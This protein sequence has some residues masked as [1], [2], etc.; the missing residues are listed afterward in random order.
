MTDEGIRL[1]AAWQFNEAVSM[2]RQAARYVTDSEFFD[3][4]VDGL[5][6]MQAALEAFCTPARDEPA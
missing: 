6:A 3:E 1:N 5:P 2:L 4:I